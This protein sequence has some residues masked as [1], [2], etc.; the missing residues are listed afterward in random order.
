MLL[1]IMIG[2]IFAYVPQYVKRYLTLYFIYAICIIIGGA[3]AT[4]GSV[5]LICIWLYSLRY[6]ISIIKISITGII[7]LCILLLLFSISS[8]GAGIE[9]FV[10]KDGLLLFGYTQGVSLMVF[11]ACRLFDNYPLITCLQNFIPGLSFTIAK[12]TGI[13]P[14]DATMQGYLCYNLNA[15]LYDNGLGLGWTTLSDLYVY[16]KGNIIV[17]SI[18]SF[19]VGCIIT[20]LEVWSYKNKFALFLLIS[21]APGLLMMSRG[22][23]ALLFIQPYYSIGFIVLFVIFFR[24][25]KYFISRFNRVV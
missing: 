3:R 6:K 25:K 10:L 20:I 19:F 11:D 4:F 16:S 5:L 23:L 24:I 22:P 13:F 1:I 15:N 2:L 21:L 12:F 17:F 8:R 14:Q 18:L 9:N 7:G